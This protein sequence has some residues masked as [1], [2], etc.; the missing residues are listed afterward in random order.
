MLP[1]HPQ[2]HLCPHSQPKTYVAATPNDDRNIYRADQIAEQLNLPRCPHVKAPPPDAQLLLTVTHHRL[3]LR[4]PPT[5]P[6]V[7]EEVR[8]GQPVAP[9]FAQLDT[10]S[11][12]GRSLK[13]PLFRA[14][15]LHKTTRDTR[16]PILDCTA[17]LL[18]DTWLLAAAGCPVTALERHPVLHL[19]LQDALNNAD[20]TH[21]DVAARINLH[22]TDALDYLNSPSAYALPPTPYTLPSHILIDPMFPPGRKTAERKPL[23]LLRLLAGPDP[24]ASKLLQAALHSAASRIVVKRPRTAPHLLDT[25]QPSHRVEGKGFRFDVY[26]SRAAAD[27]S[28]I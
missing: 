13:A 23:K 10:T 9:D 28:S 15:G 25:P 7:P 26:L 27:A 5:A 2:P 3:E 1:A 19:L 4:V 21:P 16:P 11:S 14:L 22:H 20:Y 17:G 18:E 24:D 12:A 8:G 6:D